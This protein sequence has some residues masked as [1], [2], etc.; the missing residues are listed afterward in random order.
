M[1]TTDPIT[2]EEELESIRMLSGDDLA[3]RYQE[4]PCDQPSFSLG[5]RLLR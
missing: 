1:A 3:A 4:L 5:S 2:V